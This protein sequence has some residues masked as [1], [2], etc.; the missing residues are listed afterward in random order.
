M[1]IET[2]RDGAVIEQELVKSMA[3]LAE[4]LRRR[5]FKSVLICDSEL[6]TQLSEEEWDRLLDSIEQSEIPREDYHLVFKCKCQ[7]SS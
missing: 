2:A 1:A 4:V 7:P 5:G 6:E 3:R